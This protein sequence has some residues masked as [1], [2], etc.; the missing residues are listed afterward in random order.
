MVSPGRRVP[1]AVCRASR[2]LH[3]TATP[4]TTGEDSCLPSQPGRLFSFALSCKVLS[5]ARVSDITMKV[6][7]LGFILAA[8]M[9]GLVMAAEPAN[10]PASPANNAIVP[11]PKLENDFYDWH[12]RHAAVL[13]A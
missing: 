10:P 2:C 9:G 6:K 4:Q 1:E 12:A 8:L 11:V 13:E 7:L 5:V 3:Q